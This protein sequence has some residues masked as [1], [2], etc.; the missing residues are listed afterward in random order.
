MSYYVWRHTPGDEYGEGGEGGGD[1]V[2]L[3]PVVHILISEKW[4]GGEVRH[5]MDLQP[6]SGENNT[7]YV[8]TRR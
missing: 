4:I 6:S 7:L 3:E 2:E 1:G 5:H 8:R